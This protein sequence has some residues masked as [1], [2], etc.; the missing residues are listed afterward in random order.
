VLAEENYLGLMFDHGVIG[1]RPDLLYQ[2]AVDDLD[3]P[4]V[5]A[6]VRR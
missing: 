5:F 1:P 6:A 2:F 3:K 4:R